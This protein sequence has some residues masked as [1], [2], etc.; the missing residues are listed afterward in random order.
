MY[1]FTC[2]GIFERH[3]LMFSFQMT[4]MIMDGDDIL[5]K[6]ELDFFLKGNTSLDEIEA[7]PHKWMSENGW[8]DAIKLDEMGGVFDGFVQNVK[9]NEKA[10]KEWYDLEAPEMNPMPS[11]YDKKL[12]KFQSLLICKIF[13]ND[14]CINA[15]KNFIIAQMADIYVKSPPIDYEK[16]YKQSTEKTPIIFILSPG[17]D[18]QN[19]VQRLVESHG[20]GMG[21]F[22]F[23]AL[24]QG[25]GDQAKEFIESGAI[26]GWWVMLQ[27]CHLLT[28]WLATLE[29]TI[30]GLQKPDKGF[31]LWLT[32]NPIDPHSPIRFPLGIL[33][34]SLKVV[35]E[36]PDGL[37]ANIKMMYSKLNDE[38][39]NES[40]KEEF[41]SLVYVL[42][43]FHATIQERKKFGKIGWNVNYDFNDSDYRISFNL[44]ALYLNKAIETQEEELPW[45]T[46]RYLIGE[47]MYGGR[48]TDDYDRRVLNC[49]LKE[50]FGDFIFDTNQKF[51][52]ST[53]EFDYVIPY[54]AE[55]LE[56]FEQEIEKIPLFTNP[57]VFGLHSNAEIQYFSNSVKELWLNMLLM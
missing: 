40:P 24:G 38:V 41:K 27:N 17:A 54:E 18:P 35:T 43:F 23:L 42:S 10:W 46:L 28:S 48:V 3:K 36:P 7:K 8:K 22:K 19:E 33:Q 44:I 30:E 55:N 52:F 25:M 49:Y 32:T 2:M 9:S 37:Q 56:Q 15:I 26:R 53:A 16:I 51:F 57:G 13:R 14:R 5:N 6:T 34:R 11:G 20:P 4:T 50:F 12:D 1:E 29:S 45:S 39:L 21:K 47:A 31:R